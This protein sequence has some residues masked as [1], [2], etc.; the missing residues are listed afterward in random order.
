MKINNDSDRISSR[1]INLRIG[2]MNIT[3]FVLSKHKSLEK[4]ESEIV[5]V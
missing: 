2:M 5:Q 3:A 1:K 4:K